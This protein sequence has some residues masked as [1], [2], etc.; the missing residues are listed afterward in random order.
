MEKFKPAGVSGSRIEGTSIANLTGGDYQFAAFSNDM[1]FMAAARSYTRHG[2]EI[3]EL[4]LIKLKNLKETVLMD[5]QAMVR[6]GRPNGFLYDIYFNDNGQL[7][8]KIS[9]GMEGTSILTYDPEKK[10]V[11]KDEYLEDYYDEEE[12]DV[13]DE[14]YYDQKIADLKRIFP[15]RTNVTLSELAYK[16]RPVSNKGY[17]V[18][19][20]LPNDNSIFF[21]PQHEGKLRLIHSVS[22][23]SQVDNIDGVWGKGNTAFYLLKD[24]KFD[25]FF[26]Y[27]VKANTITLL[28]KLPLH[29][30]FT[31]IYSH[32]LKNGDDLL[33]FEVE[34]TLPVAC[35]TYHL[36]K[37][38]NGQLYKV[39]DYPNLL[40]VNYLSEKNLLLLYYMDN[41]KRC[42]EVL[43][44]KK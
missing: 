34:N 22:D 15:G 3:R 31:Y 35:D 29:S 13:D 39:T 11:L 5:T 24:K 1:K 23:P 30:H 8:A 38:S 18:Q 26:K 2:D 4:V 9:D 40:D 25:Y 19:G 7:I 43:N 32:E 27:D 16:L 37:F 44:L 41:N 14:L 20:I 28:E 42:L 12:E 21:L 33:Y 36:Y 10:E 6:Y 17:F